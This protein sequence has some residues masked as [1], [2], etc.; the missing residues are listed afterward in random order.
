MV[1]NEQ[2]K[3][4]REFQPY[5]TVWPPF[6]RQRLM[7]LTKISDIYYQYMYFT[8]T[9]CFKTLY[10]LLSQQDFGIAFFMGRPGVA[11]PYLEAQARCL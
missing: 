9:H 11:I 3:R 6:L 5:C 1:G 2:A 4:E 10:N 8:Q 7:D